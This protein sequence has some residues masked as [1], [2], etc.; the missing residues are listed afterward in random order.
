MNFWIYMTFMAIIV[1]LTVIV[2]GSYYTLC[3]PNKIYTDYGY[4]TP[5]TLKNEDVW[6]FAHKCCGKTLIKERMYKNHG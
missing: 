5:L 4:K 1:P 3:P 6:A 2:V